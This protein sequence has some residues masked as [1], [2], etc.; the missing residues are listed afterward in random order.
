MTDVT[1]EGDRRDSPWQGAI[2]WLK[3]FVA[4]NPR[5]L[6]ALSALLGSIVIVLG[7]LLL[8]TLDS[9]PLA[10]S[11]P[12][13]VLSPV[14]NNPKNVLRGTALIALGM[15]LYGWSVS[16]RTP[17]FVAGEHVRQSGMM[18][19][20]LVAGP[21][22]VAGVLYLITLWL[23]VTG[24]TGITTVAP[25]LGAI[26]AS[27]VAVNSLFRSSARLFNRNEFFLVTLSAVA[28]FGLYL[29]DAAN[30]FYVWIGDEW[31][32]FG[33][34]DAVYRGVP[35]N[36]FQQSGVYNIHPVMDSVFQS[37]PMH[38]YGANVLGWRASC[39]LATAVTVFPLYLLTRLV[40]SRLSA[41]LAVG[42]FVP[43]HVM[44]AYAHV[45]YNQPDAL[46]PEIAALALFVAAQTYRAP[47]YLFFAGVMAGVGWYTLFTGRIA[48]GLLLLGLLVYRPKS[49]R[50]AGRDVTL[51][52]AG[53]IL[54]L[55]PFVI[56]NGTSI[57]TAILQHDS[58]EPGVP[59]LGIRLW[60]NGLRSIYAF[61]YAPQGDNHYVIGALVDNVTSFFWLLGVASLLTW[62][63]KPSRFILLC[64]VLIVIP[65][66]AIY[67]TL[68]LNTTRMY[69]VVPLACVVAGIGAATVVEHLRDLIPASTSR[70]MFPMAASTAI[71]TAVLV[72]NLYVFYRVVPENLQLPN[73]VLEMKVIQAHPTATYVET[74][75]LAR[76][77]PLPLEQYGYSTFVIQSQ[78]SIEDA[79]RA[80]RIHGK[81]IIVLSFPPLP[82]TSLPNGVR[83]TLWDGPHLTSVTETVIS[84]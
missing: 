81:P 62:L 2:W 27:M 65:A 59:P 78:G 47:K 69:I 26:I 82:A 32:F 35:L 34:A 49:R 72:S 39:A 79:L 46:F 25:F 9:S 4:S 31:S 8:R 70:R 57:V 77:V 83:T 15:G 52:L 21:A 64:H 63:N 67:Y 60:Q 41:V 54:V 17:V 53:F 48:I 50:D 10:W 51:I 74:G 23:I 38:L 24:S 80:A 56:V 3:L 66:G 30:W 7:M 61:V 28:A 6:A 44:L 37:L 16:S 13:T 20:Y 58:T 19:K 36:V 43:A 42:M 1:G 71:V 18:N 45:G 76:E 12:Q 55:L 14:F 75:D 29:H 68:H 84:H 5:L 33:L 11:Y 40:S 22:V 73:Q